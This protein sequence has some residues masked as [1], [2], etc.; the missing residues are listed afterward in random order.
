MMRIVLVGVAIVATT[1]SAWCGMYCSEPRAPSF[2]ESKPTK[3]DVPYC[4][5]EYSRTNS[6]DQFTI[7]NYNSEVETYNSALRS[8]RSSVELYVSELNSYLR[9]A[10]VYA[11]CEVSNL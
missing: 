2:Y 3:P 5:N 10:K 1:S 8:Y 11:D 4:I 9:K 6:C 7:D